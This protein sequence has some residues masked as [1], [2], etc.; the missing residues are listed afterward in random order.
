MS[1]VAQRPSQESLL[2]SQDMSEAN[3][4]LGV[5]SPPEEP[6][7]GT[8]ESPV[9]VNLAK[10]NENLAKSL[11]LLG[12]VSQR[13]GMERASDPDNPQTR[14]TLL[15][16]YGGGLEEKVEKAKANRDTSKEAK[17]KGVGAMARE[18]FYTA[19]GHLAMLSG[20]NKE[21]VDSMRDEEWDAFQSYFLAQ[22]HGQQRRDNYSDKLA[23]KD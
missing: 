8:T 10:R 4:S 14:D 1:K 11:I 7:F 5:Q 18:H 3:I 19:F 2:P 22:P 21:G 20:M 16:R 12:G 17:G 15:R 23:G 13:F 6:T 9:K